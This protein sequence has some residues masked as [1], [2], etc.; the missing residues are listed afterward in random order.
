M[1]MFHTVRRALGVFMVSVSVALSAYFFTHSG[2]IFIFSVDEFNRIVSAFD[3][4]YQLDL[5][6]FAP[7]NHT[8]SPAAIDTLFLRH[9]IRSRSKVELREN[10]ILLNDAGKVKKRGRSLFFETSDGSDPRFG[11]RVYTLRVFP[12]DYSGY[13]FWI[14][15]FGIVLSVRKY[16]YKRILVLLSSCYARRIDK[17][18][19]K[20]STDIKRSIFVAIFFLLLLIPL[21]LTDFQG[22]SR[23]R[24]ENRVLAKRPD[25]SLVYRHPKDFIRDV[26]LWI[27]E[28]IGFRD[29]ML[30]LYIEIN[31]LILDGYYLDGTGLVLVGEEGHTFHT[32]GKKELLSV[33]QGKPWLSDTEMQQL[34]VKFNELQSFFDRK[35]IRFIIMLCA[36]KESIYP[37]YYPKF[38]VRGSE[39]SS[40]DRV[41][42]YIRRNAALNFFCIKERLLAEKD[43]YLLYP[44]TGDIYALLHYNE[45]AGFFAYQELIKRIAAYFPSLLPLSIGDVSIAYRDDGLSDVVLR[46]RKLFKW[47]KARFFEDAI[48][49]E[50]EDV[51][52]PSLLLLRDSYAGYFT[53]FLPQHFSRTIMHHWSTIGRIE[54]Y[55]DSYK[56]DVVVFEVAE[57][58]IPAFADAIIPS[59]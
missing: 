47:T 49:Y 26:E 29:F 27:S 51:E 53:D 38:V 20:C 59:I 54:E 52:L 7:R 42:Q 46:Q 48:E 14:F 22:G 32:G 57:R 28:N 5:T 41:N 45:T 8:F 19:C 4:T 44:K 33:Y 24:R 36:D 3:K 31:K 37:E 1:K 35:G 15:A 34:M 10:G 17:I 39:P 50:N 2:W 16:P 18:S 23:G 58:E 6:P 43:E 30:S 12:I 13:L 56:P 11:R 25:I 40:L 21:F 9:A 55:V